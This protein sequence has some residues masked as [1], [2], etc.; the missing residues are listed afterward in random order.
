MA[1]EIQTLSNGE[2]ALIV[3]T[4][5]NIE[6][7]PLSAIASHSELLGEP[8]P[9]KTVLLM[10]GAAK[11]KNHGGLWKGLYKGLHSSL[12][13]LVAAGVPP[14]FMPDLMEEATGSPLP[15]KGTRKGLRDG[16][17]AMRDRIAKGASQNVQQTAAFNALLH[18][19]MDKIK[20]ARA[21]FLGDIAP[22]R[23]E[24]DP[25]QVETPPLQREKPAV[26]RPTATR[27]GMYGQ[28]DGG[29]E[30]GYPEVGSEASQLGAS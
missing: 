2:E 28:Q 1:A 17:K 8:D 9:A 7:F 12:E 23:R 26:G 13:E 21:G 15:K 14:E 3:V 10:R 24:E 29:P 19:K 11:T 27:E 20:E 6:V 16:Q 4:G 30:R 25:P 22:R 5:E 18:G